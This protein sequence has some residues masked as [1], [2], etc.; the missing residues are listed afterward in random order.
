MAVLCWVAAVGMGER[1]S[2]TGPYREGTVKLMLR[3]S[4]EGAFCNI[5]IVR[6]YFSVF[7]VCTCNS[8]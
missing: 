8:F 3:V 6:V 2:H 5:F 1:R 4:L 7:V